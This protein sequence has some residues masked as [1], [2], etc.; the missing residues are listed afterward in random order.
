MHVKAP[1]CKHSIQLETLNLK[2][3]ENFSYNYPLT[4]SYTI[5]QLFGDSSVSGPANFFISNDTSTMF[6]LK[7][8]QLRKALFVLKLY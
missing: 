3:M 5:C 7:I 8:S 6:L 4:M 2:H 1:K